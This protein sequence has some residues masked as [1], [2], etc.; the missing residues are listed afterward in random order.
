[1]TPTMVNDADCLVPGPSVTVVPKGSEFGKKR[2]MKASLTTATD[3]AFA[4]SRVVSARPRRKG[5]D[6]MSK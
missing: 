3:G 1:M 6:I 5:T 2:R 4:V